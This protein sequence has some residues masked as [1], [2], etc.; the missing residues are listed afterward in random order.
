MNQNSSDWMRH[1]RL[2][3]INPEK[4]KMLQALAMQGSRQN[5]G[6]LMSFLM[7]AAN[8]SRERGMQFSPDEMGA[9]IEV[10]KTGKSPEEAARIDRRVQMLQ[11][12]KH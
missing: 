8:T 11:M 1:P 6:D 3:N 5:R 4:L 9:V 12:M 10:L 7:S 2:A